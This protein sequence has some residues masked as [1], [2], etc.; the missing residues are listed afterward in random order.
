MHF[1]L[2]CLG[3]YGLVRVSQGT[4]DGLIY[5]LVI[6]L[7]GMGA[8]AI[9]TYFLGKGRPEFNVPFSKLLLWSILLLSLLQAGTT[10]YQSV[11]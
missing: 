2:Y 11:V 6:S 8:F 9:H 10:I 1:P 5:S 4:P 7:A 3:L